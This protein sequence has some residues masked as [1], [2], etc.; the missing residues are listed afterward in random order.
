MLPRFKVSES[1]RD[2]ELNIHFALRTKCDIEMV[3]KGIPTLAPSALPDVRRDR[4]RCPA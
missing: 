2:F 4:D 1:Q 3:P